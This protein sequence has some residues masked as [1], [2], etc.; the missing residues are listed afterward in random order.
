MKVILASGRV[1]V[2]ERLG[3][4]LA[5]ADSIELVQTVRDASAVD[6]ALLRY[7][8]V[9]V[10]VIDEAIDGGRGHTLLRTIGAANPLLGVVMLVDQA[11]PDQ[12]A[13]AMDSGARAVITTTASL[14]EVT[15]RL[16]GVG[17]WVVAARNA[18]SAETTG[19]RGGKVVAVA[20]A[21]G[22]VGASVMALLVAHAGL[23][24]QTVAVVDFDLQSGD[25]AA[26]LGVHTRRSVVDLVDVAGEITGRVL[27]EASYDVP[28]G[29]R[30]LS[31]P[32]DGE[33]AE[34]MTARA[35]RSIVSGLRYQ[36]DLSVIDVGS[37]LTES[38][39]IV[40]EEADVALLVATPD[41][42]ALRSARRMLTMWERLVIR[43]RTTVEVVLNRQNRR[44]EVTEALA[45][46]ILET[47]IRAAIPD[48]G[49]AFE[50]AM[51]TASL[52]ASSGPAH[53][54]AQKLLRA[55]E[56]S[57]APEQSVDEVVE[58]AVA[59]ARPRRKGRREAGQ[60]A[61]ELPVVI[62]MALMAFLICVQGLAWSA[63]FLMAREA[64]NEA[65]RVVSLSGWSPPAADSAR[66]E[67]RDSLSGP[68]RRD[69]R[70]DVGRDEVTVAVRTPVVWPG[71]EW[72]ASA[73]ASVPRER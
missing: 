4:I 26:Y 5:E 46:K 29:L 1:P 44:N 51:N 11:G 53:T 41:L 58:E 67:A 28:G 3:Q 10:L 23:G 40:L 57:S 22:G 21:K 37:H 66:R 7:P 50:A 19:G 20:G 18:V 62:G 38:T 73:T 2:L 43:N 34:A 61:V 64:A 30:L 24:A 32:N 15:A 17:Q 36:H 45:A 59:A 47:P 25:L 9:D 6:D 31:A 42:P 48:G 71:V 72:R 60:A 63:G 35:A 8:E 16:E 14:A 49:T 65:A 56:E 27:R 54:A 13:A 70:V 69:L 12:F 68:W 52:L 55:I 39:A 33:R